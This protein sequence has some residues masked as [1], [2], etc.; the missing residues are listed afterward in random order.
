MTPLWPSFTQSFYQNNYSWIKRTLKL[1]MLL[2][3][4]TFGVLLG[5]LIWGNDIIIL[6]LQKDL[7]IFYSTLF[8]M[9]LFALVS[10]WNNIWGSIVGAIGKVRLS[11]YVTTL[12]AITFFPLFFLFRNWGYGV[13]GAIYSMI[14]AISSSALISPIQVYYFIYKRDKSVLLTKILS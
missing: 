11:V 5:M 13:D 4:L 7:G 14:I 3:A 8:A 10:V 12:Q 1:C 6:W 9:C 2:F